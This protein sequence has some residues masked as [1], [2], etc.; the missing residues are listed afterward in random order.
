[1]TKQW[2]PEQANRWYEQ[3]PWLRGFNYLPRTAVNW[4]EMWQSE[5]FSPEIIDQELGWATEAGYNTLRTNLPFIVW[6]QDREG[7]IERLN[8]FLSITERHGIYVMIC[9]MDDCGFSGDHPYTGPQKEPVSG[10]HNSQAAASP[11]RNIVVDETQWLAVE[12]YIRDIIRTFRNDP[13]I[14]VWDLYNEPT[15]NVIMTLE[16][17]DFFDERLIPMAIRL[18]E[19]AFI[20]AREEEPSQ[21]LTVG[22]WHGETTVDSKKIPFFTHEMDKRAF[23]LSDI[24]SF[25]AYTSAEKM[26][27]MVEFLSQ[28]NRPML[29]TEW[30]GRHIGSA[31]HDQLPIF[32]KNKVACYQWGLVNGRTQTHIPWPQIKIDQPDYAS[33]WFH[34]LLHEDGTPYDPD[35]IAVIQRLAREADR[36]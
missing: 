1:M 12:D 33:R 28:F 3:L 19:Q 13:R 20:W 27:E 6:Q 9:P 11:G 25:H 26:Q 35:E 8:Q 17:K 4:T 34:D 5:T 21:P 2:T 16:G 30:L 31:F 14:L 36:K 10:L 29:C 15:N 18:M 22:A 24:I 7:L 32:M 23:E